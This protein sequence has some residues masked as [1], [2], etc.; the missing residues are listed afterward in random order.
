MGLKTHR[1]AYQHGET[2]T[3]TVYLSVSQLSA[4]IQ[5]YQGIYLSFRGQESTEVRITEDS[6]NGGATFRTERESVTL[7]YVEVPLATFQSPLRKANY[8]FPFEWNLPDTPLPSSFRNRTTNS[9]HCEVK[10]TLSAYLT[11]KAQTGAFLSNNIGSDYGDSAS[12]TIQFVGA[13]T[14]TLPEPLNI[15]EERTLINGVCCC[16]NKGHISLGWEADT[17]LLAPETECHLTVRGS[18]ESQIP[19][20]RLRIQLIQ[21]IHW[22]AGGGDEFQKRHTASHNTTMVDYYADVTHL[23][24]WHGISK[25]VGGGYQSVTIDEEEHYYDDALP[26]LQT[27]F[28]VPPDIMDTYQGHN[29]RIEHAVII[30]AVTRMLA[31]TPKVSHKIHVQRMGIGSSPAAVPVATAWMDE[32]EYHDIVLPYDWSADEKVPV[33]HLTETLALDDDTTRNAGLATADAVVVNPDAALQSFAA[34]AA[35][36]TSIVT[37][38]D[39]LAFA[40]PAGMSPTAPMEAD[41]LA[42]D[43]DL[44]DV[45]GLLRQIDPDDFN[46]QK[47][48]ENQIRNMPVCQLVMSTMTPEKYAYLVQAG[49]ERKSRHR[50]A[51]LL[52]AELNSESQ[53]FRGEYLTTLLQTRSG[54]DDSLCLIGTLIEHVCDL[55]LS[56]ASVE[57]S[58]RQDDAQWFRERLEAIRERK[59][60]AGS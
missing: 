35:A 36:A 4:E 53:G 33:I 16:W 38:T 13:P 37:G 18:N 43:S 9:G 42:Y 8:E 21:S 40:R 57:Q 49:G 14:R 50:I 44:Q 11:P 1:N 55:E 60:K 48:I 39:A 5:A 47:R 32:T 52:A 41:V 7:F 6:A 59:L 30:S 3:G 10:Y 25:E 2:M 15:A 45:Y 24:Q 23:R 56:A 54:K 26:P 22:Q 51:L 29:C 17:I 27:S 31:T 20:T 46:T 34:A 19:V 28:Q 58:L 12:Q